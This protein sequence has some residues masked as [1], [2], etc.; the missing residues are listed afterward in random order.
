MVR[1]F[2]KLILVGLLAIAVPS[3]L[4]AQVAG[5]LGPGQVVGNPSASTPA[6]PSGVGM[7]PMLDTLCSTSTDI[8]QRSGSGW[9][10]A[11]MPNGSTPAGSSGQLQYNNSGAFGG[12]TPAIATGC[13]ADG[14]TIGNSLSGTI[15]AQETVESETGDYSLESTDCGKL[16]TFSSAATL[17]LGSFTAG[18]YVDVAAQGGTLT[19]SGGTIATGMPGNLDQFE[20][21]R[22]VYDGSV[23][24]PLVGAGAE[25]TI[26]SQTI[27][28]GSNVTLSGTCA[29]T[30]LNCTIAAA[31][32]GGGSISPC[33]IDG[34]GNLS[35]PGQ[36][37]SGSGGGNTGF[38]YVGSNGTYEVGLNMQNQSSDSNAGMMV[39]WLNDTGNS[40]AMDMGITSSG[41]TA[42]NT[43][44]LILP[45]G[46]FQFSS[47]GTESMDFGSTTAG[48]WTLEAPMTPPTIALGSLPTCTF[49]MVG[50]TY[51]VID[52]APVTTFHGTLSAGDDTVAAVCT[53]TSAGDYNWVGM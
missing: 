24:W 50:Q 25:A 40:D 19:F 34:S 41:A 46:G 37:N 16:V 27:A 33:S 31:G 12:L 53:A 28:A 44:F 4:D 29:G 48:T 22:L 3:A 36:F 14:G 23:W 47:G 35:C 38:Q 39:Q 45:S 2:S 6:E 26:P 20:S 1:Y 8:L 43:G 9:V 7:S 11:A 52:A 18:Q 5:Q 10:C 30:T 49:L 32:G 21:A 17:T 51:Q 15:T 13:G 42:A